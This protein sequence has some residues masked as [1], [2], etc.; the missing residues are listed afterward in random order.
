MK[1]KSLFIILASLITIIIGIVLLTNQ[2]TIKTLTES[3]TERSSIATSISSSVKV[4]RSQASSSEQAVKSFNQQAVKANF[5]IQA[6]TTKDGQPEY[7][8][9]TEKE[10]SNLEKKNQHL[11][12]TQRYYNGQMIESV[13]AQ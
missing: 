12:I 8:Q 9:A 3:K 11:V 2:P 7:K 1:R 5:Y 13:S 10:L 4:S 6:G